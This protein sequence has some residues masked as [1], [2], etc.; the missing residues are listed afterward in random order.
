MPQYIRAKQSGG[1]FFFTVVT[2]RRWK[3]FNNPANRQSLRQAIMEVQLTHPFTID[4]WVLLPEHIHCIWTLPEGDAD[5]S[6]RWGL[7][8]AKYSKKIKGRLTTPVWQKRFWEHLIR[9]DLDLE[10]HAD[11]IHYNPVKHG[12]VEN[13][14][15]WPFSTIHRYVKEGLYPE[16]WGAGV[17]F[18]SDD[19]FGE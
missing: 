6:K 3:L 10:R 17:S 11:Y 13:P 7:I 2:H 15:D 5:F 16:D 19:R 8:K 14:R 18:D 9:D 4:A 12:L 1:T